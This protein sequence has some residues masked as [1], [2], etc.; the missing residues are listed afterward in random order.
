[1]QKKNIAL[2]PRSSL[3]RGGNISHNSLI[4]LAE[5][6]VDDEVDE[7]MVRCWPTSWE[8]QEEGMMSTS[9]SFPP[10]ET[11]VYRTNR[12]K[13]QLPKVDANWL[14]DSSRQFIYGALS[15]A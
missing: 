5:E 1:M 13:N 3:Q 7:V 15:R 14:G 4:K 11:K 12:R 10:Y 2:K 8:P 9:A 6:F